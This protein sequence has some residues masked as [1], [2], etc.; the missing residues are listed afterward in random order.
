MLWVPMCIQ[1]ASFPDGKE[2]ESAQKGKRERER[3]SDKYKLSTRYLVWCSSSAFS[4][5]QAFCLPRWA[6][7]CLKP[8][9]FAPGFHLWR[10]KLKDVFQSAF[11]FFGILFLMKQFLLDT[12]NL[13]V[14]EYFCFTYIEYLPKVRSRDAFLE[15]LLSVYGL[16]KRSCTGDA[17]TLRQLWLC[18]HKRPVV[19]WWLAG[20]GKSRDH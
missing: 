17:G 9:H 11:N 4:T 10:L 18:P 5:S 8:Q 13:L 3:Q 6:R 1:R 2:K 15:M 14:T 19:R 12:E 20:V 16:R 7:A